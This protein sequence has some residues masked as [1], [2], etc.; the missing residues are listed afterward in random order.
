MRQARLFCSGNFRSSGRL[1]ILSCLATFLLSS[2]GTVQEHRI[3]QMRHAY[4]TYPENIRASIRSAEIERGFT[5]MMAYLAWGQ[6]TATRPSGAYLARRA[7]DPARAWEEGYVYWYYVGW[8]DEEDSSESEGK[9]ASAEKNFQAQRPPFHPPFRPRSDFSFGSTN[10][11]TEMTVRFFKGRVIA[12][13]HKPF[14]LEDSRWSVQR[15]LLR[16]SPWVYPIHP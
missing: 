11:L 4:E 14:S 8:L 12:I 5:P 16:R 6:P 9:N 2:C 1:F 10:G 15:H 13:E 3:R 7:E